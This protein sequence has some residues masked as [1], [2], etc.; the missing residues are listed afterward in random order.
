VLGEKFVGYTM[1]YIE[2]TEVGEDFRIV[3]KE[4]VPSHLLPC[5]HCLP[6]EGK[7]EE[8]MEKLADTCIRFNGRTYYH[9][10]ENGDFIDYLAQDRH[11]SFISLRKSLIGTQ[12]PF[13]LFKL[14]E[15]SRKWFLSKDA[16]KQKEH[17]RTLAKPGGAIGNLGKHME[18]IKVPERTT[19]FS[20]EGKP[21]FIVGECPHCKKLPNRHAKA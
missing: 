14:G 4:K 1:D 20:I 8:V 13:M 6:I 15:P 17:L 21:I 18:V 7:S 5:P 9:E 19:P 12:N 2:I 10:Y 11:D 3:A 16:N